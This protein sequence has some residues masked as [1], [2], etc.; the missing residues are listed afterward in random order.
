MRRLASTRARRRAYRARASS[1]C[2]AIG[3]PRRPH[4]ATRAN[5]TRH[6]DTVRARAV[7][8]TSWFERATRSRTTD[9]DAARGARGET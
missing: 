8:A 7:R 2:V 1:R 9:E 6:D 3:T 4:C 5:A